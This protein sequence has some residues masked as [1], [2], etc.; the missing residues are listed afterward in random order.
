MWAILF[1]LSACGQ[2]ED[3]AGGALA[4][5]GGGGFAGLGGG[6]SNASSGAPSA[7]GSAGAADPCLGKACNTPPNTSCTS[8]ST[9]T[10]YEATG[11]CR[12]GVCSYAMQRMPCGAGCSV[13]HCLTVEMGVD[14]CNVPCPEPAPTCKD[15]STVTRRSFSGRCAYPSM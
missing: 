10:S 15:S 1:A 8:S 2:T 7:S 9:L 13:D 4:T 5:G 12:D 3:D 14:I 11:T 6:P